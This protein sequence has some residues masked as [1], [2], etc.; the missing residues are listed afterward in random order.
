MVLRGS[1]LEEAD[2]LRAGVFKASQVI[3]LA[4]SSGTGQDDGAKAG[5][6]A[7]IDADAI[8]SYQCVRRMNET[9]NCVVEIVRS[10]NVAYLD[11]EGVVRSGG[12]VEY[13]FTP[14]FAAGALFTTSLLDTLVC[15]AF[16]NNKII[17]VISEI[18]SGVDRK[19]R[20]EI[21]GELRGEIV[22]KKGV[23]AVVGSTLYQIEMPELANRTYGSLF[24]HLA[25]DGIIPIGLYRGVFPHM[26]IGPKQNKA[27]Y[28]YTNPAKD[29]E[30]FSCDK[31]YVLSPKPLIKSS[32]KG[33][34]MAEAAMYR[35]M[36]TGITSNS[37][38]RDLV[39]DFDEKLSSSMSQIIA[40]LDAN[41]TAIVTN[42]MTASFEDDS[43]IHT[44]LSQYN[45]IGISAC[46][47]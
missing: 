36:K 26:N 16:Y 40:V 17:S 1:S 2:I 32:K 9:C 22:Q 24:K 35:V 29:T 3:V 10:P 37:E 7:L 39:Y 28:V 6:E 33:I 25:A 44:S 43:S 15:Q 19:S 20:I 14:Q 21:E 46:D 27:C 42:H 13:K 4:D 18:F 11:P 5:A 31:V 41:T 8:F 30:L 45:S 12:K 47:D 38:L 23:A 34:K